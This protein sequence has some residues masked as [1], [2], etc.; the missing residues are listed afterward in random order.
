L[1]PSTTTVAH[2]ALNPVV[3]GLNPVTGTKRGKM[4]KHLITF[5]AY[6]GT[7]VEHQTHNTDMN[8]LVPALGICKEKMMK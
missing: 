8:S 7:V 2:S 6:G 3:K 1:H 5:I 4:E